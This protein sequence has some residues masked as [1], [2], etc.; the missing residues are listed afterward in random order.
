MASEFAPALLIPLLM[1]GGA[2]LSY[3]GTKKIWAR[4]SGASG[5]HEAPTAISGTQVEDAT[6]AGTIRTD[7]ILSCWRYF[8]GAASG[9][10]AVTVFSEQWP[11]RRKR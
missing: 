11:G 6:V 10:G 3:E 9:R 1:I 5:G 2:C 7:F 4:V 8:P